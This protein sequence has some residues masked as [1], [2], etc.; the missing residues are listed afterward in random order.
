MNHKITKDGVGEYTVDWDGGQGGDINII[1]N[2][3]SDW[4]CYLF[5]ASPKN[6]GIMWRPDK[7]KEPCW[8]WRKVQ[9]LLFGNMWVKEKE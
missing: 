8:F 5:G 9:Y 2:E 3:S 6:P 1:N 4:I 7:G